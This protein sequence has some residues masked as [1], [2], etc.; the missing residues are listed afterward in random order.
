ML[1]AVV[2]F[3]APPLPPPPIPPDSDS[4]AKMY[5]RDPNK[6]TANKNGLPQIIYSLYDAD[7]V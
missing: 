5:L 3:L 6:M 1:F 2:G 7:A 4:L